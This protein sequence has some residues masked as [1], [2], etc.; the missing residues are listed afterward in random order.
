MPARGARDLVCNRLNDTENRCAL[1]LLE[2]TSSHRLDRPVTREFPE[3]IRLL[4]AALWCSRSLAAGPL[5]AS[6]VGGTSHRFAGKRSV[7]A[8]RAWAGYA[9]GR[10]D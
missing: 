9:A 2:I 1:V 6:G 7:W 10:L 4:K 5:R 8:D 3:G